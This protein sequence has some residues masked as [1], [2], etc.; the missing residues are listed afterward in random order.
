LRIENTDTY[1]TAA[2]LPGLDYF[3]KVREEPVWKI[4][5]LCPVCRQWLV[6]Q[7]Y[8]GLI[9][10]N[11]AF[12]RGVLVEN[13]KLPRIF[14]RREQPFT[15]SVQRTA[16][17]LRQDLSRRRKGFNIIIPTLH[18]FPCPRCGKPLTRKF[19][20]Y[21]YHVEVDECRACKVTWFDQDE[22]EILQYLIE[23]DRENNLISGK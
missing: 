18:P 12:C 7:E 1:L 21:A 19:F 5:R 11:C 9:V 6:I 15:E 13:D 23:Q 4:R 8:E 2:E 17:L 14:T 22:L 20:S 10:L 3:F 16:E